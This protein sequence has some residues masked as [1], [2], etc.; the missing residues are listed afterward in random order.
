MFSHHNSV[1]NDVDGIQRTTSTYTNNKG[2]QNLRIGRTGIGEA[3]GWPRP[4]QGRSKFDTVP[5]ADFDKETLNLQALQTTS[6]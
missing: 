1:V 2:G 3:S 4:L 5:Q 6:Q